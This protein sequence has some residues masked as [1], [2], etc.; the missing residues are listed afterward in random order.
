VDTSYWVCSFANNQWDIAGELGGTIME[1]AFARTLKSPIKGVA[2]VLDHEV[3]PLTR[4]WCLFEFLLSKQLQLE[5]LFT[6]DL[7]VVGDDGCTSFDIAL[8]LGN[9]IES[10]QVANCLASSE[11]DKARIFEFIVESLGSLESMDNQIRSLMG[12]MLKKNL[13]NVGLATNSL[14]HR[15]GQ[16]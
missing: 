13:V 11:L 10:L 9:K 1:S 14:L 16:S 4:V 2:M 12:Q 3:Q 7:G 8:E 6:T 5:L 15:L